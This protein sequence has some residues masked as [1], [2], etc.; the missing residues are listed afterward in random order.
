MD[1]NMADFFGGDPHY[2]AEKEVLSTYLLLL[3]CLEFLWKPKQ[4]GV[5]KSTKSVLLF[6]HL[7]ELRK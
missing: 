5:Q 6:G 3:A 1:N 7:A 2:I 4:K